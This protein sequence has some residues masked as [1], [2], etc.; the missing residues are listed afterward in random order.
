MNTYYSITIYMYCIMFVMER[1]P[2]SSCHR[3]HRQGFDST[4]LNIDW[5]VFITNNNK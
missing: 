5:S 2:F 4:H 1:N 3:K